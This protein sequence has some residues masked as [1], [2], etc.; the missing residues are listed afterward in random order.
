M[1]QALATLILLAAAMF[2]SSGSALADG[3]DYDT[4]PGRIQSFTV[5]CNAGHGAFEIF[6]GTRAD[7]VPA[8]ARDGGI[9]DTTGPTNS[10][11]AAA[12]RAQ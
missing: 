9:G 4:N 8:A 6:R 10:G 11:A 12:C 7:W 3:D 5:S 1:R 2:G